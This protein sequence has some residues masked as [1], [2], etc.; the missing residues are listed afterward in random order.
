MSAVLEAP[1]DAP[2][3]LSLIIAVP[4]ALAVNIS[5]GND[6]IATANDFV[7]DCQEMATMASQNMTACK[8][9]SQLM[10]TGRKDF[11]EPAQLII[12]RAK[13][14]FNPPL[15]AAQEAEGIYKKKL[16]GWQESERA[17]IELENKKREEV[18][19][20]LRQEADEKAAKERAR[21]AE[22]ARQR[23][24]EARIAAEARAKAEAEARVAAEAKRKA[25]EEGNKEAARLAAEQERTAR[26][27][28]QSRAA[29]EAKANEQATSAIENG[30]AMAQTAQLEAA[31]AVT[32]AAPLAQQKVVG[33]ST[34][35]NW[36]AKLNPLLTE[37]DVKLLIAK[38]AVAGRT[39]LLGLLD[40]NM[41]A[42][43]KMAKALESAFVVPGMTAANEP[44]AVGSRK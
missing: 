34:K 35:K 22:I 13:K 36:V 15:L 14:W 12:E 19:R 9:F 41:G 40:L 24:Q 8:K 17:R 3:D 1:V 7:I 26:A 5:Q 33:F 16:L 39:D 32:S 2:R 42:A 31:A 44:V 43:N 28:A 21:A 25:I 37:N 18:A 29:A 30:E 4:P 11:L 20:K 6:L 38:A 23:E 10:E 27:E